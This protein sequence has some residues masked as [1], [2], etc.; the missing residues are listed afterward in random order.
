LQKVTVDWEF[1]GYEDRGDEYFGVYLSYHPSKGRSYTL[2]ELDTF[3]MYH[4]DLYEK[5]LLDVSKMV[6]TNWM[7]DSMGSKQGYMY[8]KACLIVKR[9]KIKAA[10][11]LEA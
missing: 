1:G 10:K 3:K 6:A 7:E 5:S 4:G 9:F 2:V 8:R 11:M